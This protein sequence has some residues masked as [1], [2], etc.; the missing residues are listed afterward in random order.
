MDDDEDHQEDRT[1]CQITPI[2]GDLD[3]PGREDGGAGHGTE[4]TARHSWSNGKDLAV[5]PNL[6]QLGNQG[7]FEIL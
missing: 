2:K 5:H 4:C 6:L 3:V 7:P 1:P